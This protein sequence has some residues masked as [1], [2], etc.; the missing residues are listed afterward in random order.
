MAGYKIDCEAFFLHYESN[1]WTINGR[2]M[3]NWRA[4]LGVWAKEEFKRQD[5]KD[6]KQPGG[7]TRERSITE[8]LTDTSWA[9][10]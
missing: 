1:G 6:T 9:E 2:V 4:R 3:D 8:D 7:S 5:K 10:K